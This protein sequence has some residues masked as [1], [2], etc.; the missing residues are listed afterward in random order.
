MTIVIRSLAGAAAVTFA[1]VFT[2]GAAL[3]QK[4]LDKIGKGEGKVGIVA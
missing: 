4:M 2:S 1:A 3:A